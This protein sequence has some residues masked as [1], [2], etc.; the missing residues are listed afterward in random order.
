LRTIALNGIQID[1]IECDVGALVDEVMPEW[2][3][4]LFDILHENILG[5]IDG[6]HDRSSVTGGIPGFEVLEQAL[7]LVVWYLLSPLPL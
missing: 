4:D 7:N 2:R 5:V 3:L 6:P 1:V